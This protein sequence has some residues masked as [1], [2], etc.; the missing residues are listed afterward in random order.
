M[1]KKSEIIGIFVLNKYKCINNFD[2]ER[3]SN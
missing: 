3:V 2:E 1:G